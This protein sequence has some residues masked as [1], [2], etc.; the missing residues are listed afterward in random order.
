MTD[1]RAAG[2][3]P[4]I[5]EPACATEKALS[6]AMQ[7]ASSQDFGHASPVTNRSLSIFGPAMPI[8]GPA[9]M[10]PAQRMIWIHVVRPVRH[11]MVD[12][13]ESAT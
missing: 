6:A 13:A 1:F 10:V 7:V 9:M 12:L 8:F 4:Q 11:D 3:N 2:T 5:F